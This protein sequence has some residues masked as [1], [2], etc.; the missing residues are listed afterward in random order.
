MSETE[1]EMPAA[2][3]VVL[4][5]LA[6]T[7]WVLAASASAIGVLGFA[8]DISP[9]WQA[10]AFAG[11]LV[12]AAFAPRRTARRRKSEAKAEA[13]VGLDGHPARELAEAVPDP[14]IVFDRHG[15]ITNANSAARAAFGKLDAGT[16]LTLRF[17]TPELQGLVGRLLAGAESALACD[18]VERV[19]IE[20][21]FRVSGAVLGQGS[22]LCVLVFKDQSEMRRID[23]MRSDFIANASHELR[24]PLASIAGFIETLRGPARNDAKAR[25]QFLQIMQTQTGRMARLIDDLLSLSRLEMKS[26]S[27]PAEPLDLK[28]LIDGVVDALRHLAADNG[29]EIERIYPDEPVE[30]RGMRDE[31]IQVFENLLENAIKYGQDGKRVVVTVEMGQGSA[32]PRVTVRDFGPGVPE[33]HIPRLTERFYRV[34]VDTSRTQKGTGLGLAIVK[35]ILTRH[36]AR[37]T[38]RSK[39]GEGAA[40]TVHFPGK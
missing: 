33:E 4:A 18:Y 17:R 40:F 29:V 31:L 25:E 37:L 34:D 28:G 39:V 23:R 13:V 1:G 11:I 10:L 19:P 6:D 15:L 38:I 9:L 12:V 5:R 16:L 20:R 2:R 32:G 26:F 24:T 21:W 7:R 3:R 30:L 8:A 27:A 35:H 14:L 22:G 36:D